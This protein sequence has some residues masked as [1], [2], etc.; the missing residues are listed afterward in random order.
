MRPDPSTTV[1]RTYESVRS[2]I[3][4]GALPSGTRIDEADVIRSLSSSRTAVREAF[5]WL[6]EEGLVERRQRSGT[7]VTR[8]PNSFT[9][10]R[11]TGLVEHLLYDRVDP[12][13]GPVAARIVSG[14]RMRVLSHLLLTGGEP[15]AVRTVYRSAEQPAEGARPEVSG[16]AQSDFRATFG[17]DLARIDTTV[18]AIGCDEQTAQL[19]RVAPG[20]PILLREQVL[21]GVDGAARLLS[22]AHYA[23]ARSSFVAGLAPEHPD[24]G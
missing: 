9:G 19:L 11:F 1:A 12:A 15:V 22:Q 10:D 18:E 21:V 13:P 23:G 4:S 14:G 3:R 17:I 16:S 20:S 7:V 6:A 8:V 24:A 2:A 5:T